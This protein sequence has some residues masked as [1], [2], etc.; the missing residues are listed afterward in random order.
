MT[1]LEI[2]GILSTAGF[3]VSE[4]LD[5]IPQKYIKQGSVWRMVKDG[6]DLLKKIKFF[7]R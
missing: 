3:I 6:A 2:L 4:I 7:K 1:G 5:A